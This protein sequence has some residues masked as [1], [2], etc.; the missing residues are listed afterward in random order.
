MHRAGSDCGVLCLREIDGYRWCRGFFLNAAVTSSLN[1][2]RRHL[3]GC[4]REC[5]HT[6]CLKTVNFAADGLSFENGVALELN[7]ALV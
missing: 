5:T 1:E 2:Q 3:Q 4:C 6:M 7:A